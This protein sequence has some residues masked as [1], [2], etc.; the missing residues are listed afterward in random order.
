M[1]S[2]RRIELHTPGR[3]IEAMVSGDT[4]IA[5]AQGITPPA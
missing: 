4:R 5:A 1:N 2:G 3:W